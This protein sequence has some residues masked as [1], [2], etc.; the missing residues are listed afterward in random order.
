MKIL[1]TTQQEG[2]GLFYI[3]DQQYLTPNVPVTRPKIT[4]AMMAISEEQLASHNE[5]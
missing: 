4:R 5:K 1:G 2:Y 3:A